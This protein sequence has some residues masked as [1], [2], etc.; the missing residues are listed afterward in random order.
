[1]SI[2]YRALPVQNDMQPLRLSGTSET[3][4]QLR[5][6]TESYSNSTLTPYLED[7]TANTLTAIPTDGSTLIYSFQGV[8]SS[9]TNPDNRFRIVYQQTLSA[10]DNAFTSAA[11]YPNPVTNQQLH[12]RLP[13]HAPATYQ[14]SNLLGQVIQK[15]N[16]TAIDNV[17]DLDIE[18]GVYMLNIAQGN[19]NYTNK[20]IVK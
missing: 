11:V 7:L 15:G 19:E 8:V 14:V 18:S 4:Y 12:I 16:L 6:F 10:T 9:N 3:A 1:L 2:E 13:Q 20:I 5:I 17:V